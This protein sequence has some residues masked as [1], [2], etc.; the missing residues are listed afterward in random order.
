MGITIQIQI[1][2]TRGLRQKK[3]SHKETWLRYGGGCEYSKYKEE[4]S[5][6]EGIVIR[7]GGGVWVRFTGG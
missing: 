4:A 7:E 6:E 1:G 2:G 3:N 5:S